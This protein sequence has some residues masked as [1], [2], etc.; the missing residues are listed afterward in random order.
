MKK[1][2][3]LTPAQMGFLSKLLVWLSS[4]SEREINIGFG[5]SRDVNFFIVLIHKVRTLGQYDIS[6]KQYLECITEEYYKSVK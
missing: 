2:K 4:D 5:R 6:D 3:N 1:I